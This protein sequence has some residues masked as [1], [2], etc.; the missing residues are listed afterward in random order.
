VID[1]KRE[2]RRINA[3]IAHQC[4][5]F[6]IFHASELAVRTSVRYM[7]VEMTF[8][9]SPQLP[10]SL[11]ETPSTQ[12]C[13][14]TIIA[15]LQRHSPPPDFLCLDGGFRK[16]TLASVAQIGCHSVPVKCRGELARNSLKLCFHAKHSTSRGKWADTSRE[17]AG[18]CSISS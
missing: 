18:P 9:N 15:M 14:T 16:R 10:R 6:G 5:H 2:E 11:R 7:G 1:V 12:R 4:Q 13:S 17:S 8:E 3:P